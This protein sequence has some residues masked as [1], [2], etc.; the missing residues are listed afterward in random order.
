MVLIVSFKWQVDSYGHDYLQYTY[1]MIHIMVSSARPF[2]SIPNLIRICY[3]FIS[4][5]FPEGKG[6]DFVEPSFAS[7]KRDADS[8]IHG[9]ATLFS[10]EDAVKL[11]KQEAV[12]RAYNL[13]ICSALLYDRKTVIDVEVYVPTKPLDLNYPE[14]VCSLRYR[15]ILVQGAT[16]V[17]LD[18]EWIEKLQKLPVYSPSV[19]TLA[20]RCSLP[21]LAALPQMTIDT[22]ALHNGS[23]IDY[24]HYISSCGYVF[25]LKDNFDVFH[26]R[27][28]TFRNVLHS[29]GINL[30]H[31]DDGGKAPFPRLS[32]LEHT[33][34]E[35]AL[36]YRDR[37]IAKTGG[38]IAILKEFWEDQ[39]EEFESVFK[40]NS[41][42]R[43]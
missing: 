22:L 7:A 36:Q 21:P 38:P 18:K 41:L 19:Q 4:Y 10:I 43:I 39:E 2:H 40:G 32:L 8:V 25:K 11:N 6:L 31:N 24:P 23:S 14:G 30:E 12:G 28:I 29:R 16:E 26:G 9:V 42:S 35:Y 15:N 20:L 5:S 34:L 3:F 17:D 27:D 33:G 37:F 13:E 1:C